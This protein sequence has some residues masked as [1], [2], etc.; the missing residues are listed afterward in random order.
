LPPNLF[1]IPFF[2]VEGIYT[3][4]ILSEKTQDQSIYIM[5]LETS[6]LGLKGQSGGPICDMEGNITQY[7]HKM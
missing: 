1:P 4:N 2:P 3:R 5:F 6:S 7:N